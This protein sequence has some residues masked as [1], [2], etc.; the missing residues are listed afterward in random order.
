MLLAAAGVTALSSAAL[1][2]D[3]PNQLGNFRASTY[4]GVFIPQSESWKGSGTLNGLPFNATGKLPS[5]TGWATGGFV[6][7]TFEDVPGWEWLNID[8]VA[9]YI[10]S[11]FNQFAGTLAIAGV[12]HF[13]GPAPLSGQYHTVAEF[14]NFL[15]LRLEFGGFSMIR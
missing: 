3:G 7:Y 5:N 13:T 15:A 1:A 10:A 14:V 2:D 4:G 11:T 9:R 12:G 8:L 6:G